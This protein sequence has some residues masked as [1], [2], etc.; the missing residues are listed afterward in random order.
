VCTRRRT[1][2]Y[3]GS[4]IN[5]GW[6]AAYEQCAAS[7]FRV[8]LHTDTIGDDKF[9]TT[10]SVRCST[11]RIAHIRANQPGKFNIA[12]AE[13]NRTLVERSKIS[14]FPQRR[15]HLHKSVQQYARVVLSK[16][17]TRANHGPTWCIHKHTYSQITCSCTFHYPDRAAS[18][19]LC[20]LATHTTSCLL[21]CRNIRYVDVVHQST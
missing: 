5:I 19:L 15:K 12:C 2:P 18:E 13:S 11:L 17:L 3:K 9:G 4:Q 10:E 6:I 21:S 20:L 16:S 14:K 7:I 1:R 8:H